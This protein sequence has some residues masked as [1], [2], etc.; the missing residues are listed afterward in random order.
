MDQYE[1][2]FLIAAPH[3]RLSAAYQRSLAIVRQGRAT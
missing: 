1:R 2:V 3:W